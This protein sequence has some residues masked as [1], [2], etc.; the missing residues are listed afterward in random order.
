LNPPHPHPIDDLYIGPVGLEK[1][2][3]IKV[4]RETDSGQLSL[5]KKPFE[6]M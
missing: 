3:N 1:E 2:S 5:N 6:Y 4:Y